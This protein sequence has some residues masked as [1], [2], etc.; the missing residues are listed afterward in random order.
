MSLNNCKARYARLSFLLLLLFLASC[1]PK[2]EKSANLPD[3][4]KIPESTENLEEPKAPINDTV[5]PA[6]VEKKCSL[7]GYKYFSKVCGFNSFWDKFTKL[8][9]EYVSYKT[10]FSILAVIVTFFVF[11]KIFSN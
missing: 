4:V 6:V 1:T 11:K 9:A 2:V 7:Q 5:V 10:V 8:M 3:F